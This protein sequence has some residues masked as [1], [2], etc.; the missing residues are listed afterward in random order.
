MILMDTRHLWN[1][2]ARDSIEDG[3]YSGDRFGYPYKPQLTPISSIA[4]LR[5]QEFHLGL[6]E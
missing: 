5:G 3:Q 1:D 4:P 2:I 6:A